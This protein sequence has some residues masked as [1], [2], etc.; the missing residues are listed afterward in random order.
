MNVSWRHTAAGAGMAI[1]V[2]T[3]LSAI[4]EPECADC[5]R[6]ASAASSQGEAKSFAGGSSSGVASAA[7]AAFYGAAMA[8]SETKTGD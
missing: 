5:T 4:G 1:L 8:Q 3:A 7:G 2:A 6:E